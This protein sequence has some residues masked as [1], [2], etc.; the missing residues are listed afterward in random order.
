[1]FDDYKQQSLTGN[2][3]DTSSPMIELP[4]ERS[5]SHSSRQNTDLKILDAKYYFI[6]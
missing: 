1:M 3:G 4:G 5:A 2:H 6:M